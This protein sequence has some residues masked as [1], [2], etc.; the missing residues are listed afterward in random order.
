MTPR[1]IRLAIFVLLAC[2]FAAACAP[3]AREVDVEARIDG[4]LGAVRDRTDGFGWDRLR[5]D[6]RASYPGGQSAWI[7][8][9]GA[10]ETSGLRWRIENVFVDDYVGCARVHF[11]GGRQHVPVALFDDDLPA[12]ARVASDIGDGS[13]TICATVG[14]LPFD[15]G[16]HGVG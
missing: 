9:M 11:D 6:V 5:D 1:S 12:P 2:T 10:G 16:V 8:A 7:A 3:A 14:P 4:F 15:A 13:F